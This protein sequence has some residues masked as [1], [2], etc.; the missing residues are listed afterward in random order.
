MI[1]ISR[2]SDHRK[3]TPIP[4]VPAGGKFESLSRVTAFLLL[5]G[6]FLAPVTRAQK[7]GNLDTTFSSPNGFVTTN[8]GTNID[9]VGYAVDSKGRI[10]AVGWSG[11]FQQTIVLVRYNPDGTLDDSFGT[12]GTN[13]TPIK[14]QPRSVAIDAN[15]NVLVAGSGTSHIFVARFLGSTGNLDVLNFGAAG[16]STLDVSGNNSSTDVATAMAIDGNGSIVVAG[17]SDAN[18]SLDFMLARFTSQGQVDTTFGDGKGWVLTD[19]GINKNDK[20]T[21]LAI[22][23][24]TGKIVAVG[25]AE[26]NGGTGDFA[27]ARYWSDGTLDVTFGSSSTVPG[28]VRTDFSNAGSNEEATGVAVIEGL[29]GMCVFTAGSSSAS[30]VSF[31]I[32]VARYMDD[33]T[34]DISFNGSGKL[35]QNFA[36]AIANIKSGTLTSTDGGVTIAL[37]KKGRVVVAGPISYTDSQQQTHNEMALGRY[38]QQGNLDANFGSE[39]LVHQAFGGLILGGLGQAPV[40]MAV[41]ASGKIVAGDTSKGSSIGFLVARFLSEAKKADLALTMHGPATTVPGGSAD[42]SI[43]VNNNGPDDAQNVTLTV[44]L[45]PQVTTSGSGCSVNVCTFAFSSLTSGQ[46]E[47]VLL[48]TTANSNVAGGTAITSSAS[49]TSDTDDSNS[50]NNSSS[51]S[52]IVESSD[53]SISKQVSPSGVAVGGTVTYTLKVTNYGPSGANGIT[54][55]DTL[56]SSLTYVSNS[57]TTNAGTCG[58]SNGAITVSIPSLANQGVV[59]ITLQATLNA[60]ASDGALIGNMAAVQSSSNDPNSSNNSSTA[61]FVVQNKADLRVTLTVAKISNRQVT[62]TATVKNNGPYTAAQLALVDTIP[63]GT[64]FVSIAPGAWSCSTPAVG[65]RGNVSC[66]LG[67]LGPNLTSTITFAVKVT[68]PG[69][70]SISDTA[71]VSAA[72]SDPNTSNNSTTLATKLSAK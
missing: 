42:Y 29:N 10:V 43:T 50:S 65:G 70:V 14:G 25:S 2:L 1:L 68:V 26:A 16:V 56:P 69:S 20:A 40:F 32:A 47:T 67:S 49:V 71:T 53:L 55:G 36:V 8:I 52:T 30:G 31:D 3:N 11:A 54:V 61:Y 60:G 62:Y 37:D 45:S 27:L 34:L 44:Q 35:I 17:S 64:N 12:G 23:A 9:V 72:T 39:G 51:A 28:T 48:K 18:G 46:S 15:D 5:V 6:V 59:T 57:C 22:G 19:F 24:V 21:A 13:V 33:G 41:D 7:A 58:F 4:S 38:D 63:S 66:S